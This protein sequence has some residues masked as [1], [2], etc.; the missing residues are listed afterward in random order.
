MRVSV[1]EEP[2]REKTEVIVHARPGDPAAA[3]TADRIR[4]LFGRLVGYSSPGSP[5][6]TVID[7]SDVCLIELSEGLPWLV[8]ADGRRLESPSKLYELV[9]ALE[10]GDFVQVSRQVVVNLEHIAEIRP[11]PNGRLELVMVGGE[12]A[13]VSRGY[14]PGLRRRLGIAR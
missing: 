11:A 13:M 5:A 12:V 4:G 6:K 14:A 7:R 9:A 8:L 1:M 10:T 3:P 2:C